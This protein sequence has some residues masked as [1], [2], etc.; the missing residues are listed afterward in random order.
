MFHE[1]GS[2]K[3]FGYQRASA[4]SATSRYTIFPFWLFAVAWAFVSYAVAAAVSWSW[5]M[6]PAGVAGMGASAASVYYSQPAAATSSP[7]SMGSPFGEWGTSEEDD[8]DEVAM[9]ISME[10]APLPR[11][12]RGRPRKSESQLASTAPA[13]GTQPRPGYYV[14]DPTTRDGL[15]K[16]I[17]YGSEPP[18]TTE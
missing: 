13:I 12:R 3:E 10:P 2:W 8:D 6:T 9:P 4:I 16:Y 5:S 1:N 17:Y 18:K 7:M 11:R 15:R 14:L